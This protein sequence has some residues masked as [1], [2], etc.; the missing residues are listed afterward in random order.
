MGRILRF[1]IVVA[2]V[3]FTSIAWAQT[4]TVSGKVTSK[5]DGAALPG[6]NVVV[7]GT[8]NGT[9]TDS[10]GK[11][12]LALPE[13]GGALVFSFIGLR[14]EEIE[15]G[16]RTTV[17]V[18]LNLDVSQLQEVVVTAQGLAREKKALGYSVSTVN[19]EQ[20]EARPVNDISAVLR[21]KVP[22]VVIN[23]T[24][25]MAGSG[26][27]IN[28]RGF[29]SLTGNTQP[30]WVV[31]GVPFNSDTN[32]N[33]GFS[34][35][36]AATASSRFLDLDPNTIQSVTVL[37]GL[38]AATRYGD[39]GR[40]GV[41]L[42]T[43][44][45]GSTKAGKPELT[46]QQS[47]SFSKIASLPDF[48]NSYGAGFQQLYG[49]F[50]S[51]WGPNFKEIDSVAHPFQNL[52]DPTLQYAYPEYFF[53]RIP[54]VAA[55]NIGGFFRT[56]VVS[57]TSVGIS[58]GTNKL[59]YNINIA[60]TSEQGYTPGNDLKRLNI[61]TGFNTAVTDKFS[62][63][64][65]VLYSN[66]DIASPPLNTATGGGAANNGVPSL[67][68][69]FLYTP[70]NIDI[71]NMPYETPAPD[72]K[73]IFYRTGNDIPNAIWISKYAKETDVT[74][75][76]FNS[77]SFVYDFT[78]RLSLTYKAGYDTY[79]EKQTRGIN[80]GI[81]PTYAV[82]DRGIYQ[83]NNITNSIW[84]HDIIISYQKQISNSINMTGLLGGNARNDVYARD[85]IYTE[86]QSVF[87]VLQTY[88][89]TTSSSRDIG[90][91]GNYISSK[92][93]Q[94]RYGVYADFSFDYRNF[95]YLN[96]QGRNDWNSALEKGHNT[97]FYPSASVAFDAT[98]AFSSIKS[99]QLNFLKLR[100]GYGTSANFGTPY[101]TRTIVSQNLRGYLPFGT[102]TTVPGQ[103][104]GT[105]LGNPKLNP[106][107]QQEIEVGVEAKLF[108]NRVTLDVS[109]YQRTTKDLITLAPV[110]PS[111]GYSRTWANVGKLEN[112]GINFA[113]SGTALK[114]DNGLQ[115][116][117][118]WNFTKVSPKVLELGNGISEI[119][120]AGFT[121]RGNFAMPGQPTNIIKGLAPLKDPNGNSIVGPDG[122]YIVD[123]NIQ[124]LGNPNP[125]YLTTLINSVSFKGFTFAFQFDYR[126][127]GKMY[128]STPSAVIGRGVSADVDYNH[129]LTF[130]LP[131]VR[132]AG[133][134]A[135][136]V[137]A[138]YIKNDMQ[139]TAS[140]YGFNTQ[141]NG[142]DAAAMFDGTTI[143]LREVSLRYTL[144]TSWFG[145]KLPLKGASIMLTGNN[146]WF[147]A[148]NVP[149]HV[150]FDPEVSSQ[151]V[152]NG[153]G[154]DYLTGPS[155]KR[156]GAVLRLTF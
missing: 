102:T 125:D 76:F 91:G 84:N 132:Q 110:D 142:T 28:I 114:L 100:V 98:E 12:A 5:D 1:K 137:T 86:G 25:G 70:R 40:N 20:L 66:T 92:R 108:N 11:Y 133:F 75:R 19:K 126:K 7:K 121:T 45:S 151:G 62:I 148:V 129:D 154:F 90:F 41:I 34:T 3:F 124:I 115:W 37:S 143:R 139:I 134:E 104:Y 105:T 24:G 136:G 83:V 119:V 99:S 103:T 73:S 38:A 155:V 51:N 63:K 57:N 120:L 78:D 15:I 141:F 8:S 149:K 109:A 87:G 29:S 138:H 128:A 39:Q 64:Y 35:G 74:N 18:Q 79:T 31:D 77:A 96:L 118:T 150:N 117:V 30:L 122:L 101:S 82:P 13:S 46:F 106:E 127:G 94:Q 145:R 153:L 89:F 17:D 144:P 4:R 80:R 43:T 14:T 49:A 10:D 48:Q 36:G 16:D 81:G 69:N 93:E 72:H 21:G 68:A 56:G 146:L 88:N 23:P 140:D 113:L 9:T 22:G 42:V 65:S 71:L 152:G 59:G 26:S 123:P 130:V 135:D 32:Q 85:G 112:K 95:L 50:F 53:K 6:V 97:L 147:N 33:S 52:S 156:Y 116:D 27:S 67:Y 44:K 60:N 47:T 111:T 107:L 55:P 58:G 131:G 2:L 54:Y 61:T